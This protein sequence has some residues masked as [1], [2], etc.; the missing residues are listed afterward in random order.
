MDIIDI[1]EI[2]KKLTAS[3]I[4]KTM[5]LLH[6]VDSTNTYALSIIKGIVKIPQIPDYNGVVV[7]SEIQTGGKG[8]LG[9]RWFSPPGG[10]W[11]TIILKPDLKMQDLSKMTLLSAATIADTLIKNYKISLNIKWPNDIYFEGKKLCG[12]LAESEKV[13]DKTYLIIGIGIN[14]NNDCC[15][16]KNENINAAS[17]KEITGKQINRDLLI[18]YVLNEFETRYLYYCKSLDFKD[19]FNEIK[20]IM[21][22]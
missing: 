21:I 3:V 17:L 1:N 11:M 13:D 6:T 9:R 8:R 18:A 15:D 16:Y 10:I 12:I 19:I 20:N 7:I 2:Q 5:I 4:G 22:Y 14:I